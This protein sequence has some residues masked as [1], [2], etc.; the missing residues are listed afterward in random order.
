MSSSYHDMSNNWSINFKQTYVNKII[1]NNIFMNIV[2]I[3][4]FPYRPDEVAM[5]DCEGLSIL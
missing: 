2:N 4:I 5:F 3:N 1:M